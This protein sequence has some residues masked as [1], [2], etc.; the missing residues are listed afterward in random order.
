MLQS[1]RMELNDLRAAQRGEKEERVREIKMVNQE[2]VEL[3]R[4]LAQSRSEQAEA[5]N[6]GAAALRAEVLRID[7]AVRDMHDNLSSAQQLARKALESDANQSRAAIA[8]LRQSLDTSDRSQTE[9]LKS[10]IERIDANTNGDSEFAK[11]MTNKLDEQTRDLNLV[12][13][14][15]SERITSIKYYD[16]AIGDLENGLSKVQ[17]RLAVDRDMVNAFVQEEMSR[18]DKAI[19]EHRVATAGA[20]QRHWKTMTN[21]FTEVRARLN[22][23]TGSLAQERDE[24]TQACEVV[25]SRVDNLA[26]KAT[27]R[28]APDMQSSLYSHK[29]PAGMPP[30]LYVQKGFTP[31]P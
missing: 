18:M 6:R 10:L 1:L 17:D 19:D 7:A 12:H 23:V 29:S 20:I 24:R 8:K 31:R 28:G 16:K 2:V 14:E 4:G 5:S 15:L 21:D 11:A 27:W 22:I 30:S 9:A 3:R 26:A 25:G 13:Q